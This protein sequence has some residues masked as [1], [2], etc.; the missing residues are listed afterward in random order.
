MPREIMEKLTLKQKRFVQ[1]YLVDL[2]ATQAA[3]RAG[4]S[5]R[6][7]SAIANETLAKPEIKAAI[8]E[9][10]EKRGK[11]VGIDQDRTLLE[12]GRLAFSDVRQLFEGNRLKSVHELDDHTA[13]A[14][15]SVKVV[16]RPTGVEGEVEYVHEIKLWPKAPALDMAGRHIGLFEKDNS[17]KRPLVT[18]KNL[19]GDPAYDG[20]D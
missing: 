1:E 5:K 20:T 4:Y 15:A 19:S 8:A 10:M 16:T 17:Q 12:I 9:A 2:N 18:I 11:R 14:V 13:A 7:S 6:S 3:I